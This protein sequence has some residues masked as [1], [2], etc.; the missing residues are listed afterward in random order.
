[1]VFIQI[2][3]ITSQSICTCCQILHPLFWT[4]SIAV[5]FC[6]LRLYSPNSAWIMNFCC[7]KFIPRTKMDID[8]MHHPTSA[9]WAWRGSVV[10]D[11]ICICLIC[12]LYIQ[13]V[14]V[15]I[16]TY[17]K[18]QRIIQISCIMWPQRSALAWLLSA[19]FTISS[20]QTMHNNFSISKSQCDS[21]LHKI[22][23]LWTKQTTKYVHEQIDDWKCQENKQTANQLHNFYLTSYAVIISRLSDLTTWC[24]EMAWYFMLWCP[25]AE[26]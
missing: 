7:W 19:T 21:N 25:L 4:G 3:T 5:F 16:C 24:W 2:I 23:N 9:N 1:M 10:N 14:Y 12:I 15:M 18:N 11:D 22:I 13:Y 8:V 17:C 26:Y 20:W 6:S